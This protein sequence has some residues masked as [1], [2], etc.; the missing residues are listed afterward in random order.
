MFWSGTINSA[1]KPKFHTK[2]LIITW[3]AFVAFGVLVGYNIV[4]DG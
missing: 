4:T 3:L 1:L 2:M